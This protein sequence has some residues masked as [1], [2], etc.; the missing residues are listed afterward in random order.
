LR[1]GSEDYR[2]L[3]IAVESISKGLTT[4]IFSFDW[5]VS[6]I[7]EYGYFPNTLYLTEL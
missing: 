4:V 7:I 1:S 5:F 6:H 2:K 3:L